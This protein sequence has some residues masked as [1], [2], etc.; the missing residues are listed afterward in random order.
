MKHA[1]LIL[2]LILRPMGLFGKIIIVDTNGAGSFTSI[3]AAIN[4]AVNGDT[5]KE[6]LGSY[7]GQLTLSKSIVLMG[8]G[9]GNTIITSNN[10]P[11]IYISSE[12]II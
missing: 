12:T 6:L 2:V 5:S 10:D 9:Y 7:D 11:T 1:L 4:A 8:S 3:P